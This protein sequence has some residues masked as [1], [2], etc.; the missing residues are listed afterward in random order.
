[1]YLT[2]RMEMETHKISNIDYDDDND[3]DELI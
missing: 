2:S 1:M 3:Y